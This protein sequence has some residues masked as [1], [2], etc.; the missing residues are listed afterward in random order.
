MKI[1][2]ILAIAICAVI[3]GILNTGCGQKTEQNTPVPQQAPVQQQV[4]APVQQESQKII[5]R[6]IPEQKQV[7]TQ[8]PRQRII[9]SSIPKQQAQPTNN[10]KP[11]RK[12]KLNSHT[13][14]G[15]YSLQEMK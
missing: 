9:P 14:K 15:D 11:K 8:T 7:R 10:N 5:P 3:I 4:T 13:R 6:S 12:V 2:N 1:N